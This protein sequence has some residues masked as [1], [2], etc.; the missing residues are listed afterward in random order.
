[1]PCDGCPCVCFFSV[2]LY[3]HNNNCNKPF[4]STNW[5]QK[6]PLGCVVYSHG[7]INDSYNKSVSSCLP[8]NYVTKPFGKLQRV[9][10][11]Q[12]VHIS[13]KSWKLLC[14]VFL[15]FHQMIGILISSK[16]LFSLSRYSN[17]RNFFPF[18]SHFLDSKGQMKYNNLCHELACI[19]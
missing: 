1:M 10:E 11:S 18:F 5:R 19:Y 8:W 16:K 15:F 12:R 9:I 14:T 7:L 4:A 3:Y 6:E 17:L 2:L 13:E